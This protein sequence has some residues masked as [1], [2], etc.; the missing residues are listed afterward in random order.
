M[1]RQDLLTE[2][3]SGEHPLHYKTIFLALTQPWFRRTWIIQEI[4]LA[5]RAKFMFQG[6][7]FGRDYLDAT[8]DR[9]ELMRR[10]ERMQELLS[11]ND[12]IQGFMNYNKIKEIKQMYQQQQNDS[13]KM[14]QLTRDFLATEPKDKIYGLMA[15]M[16][17]YDQEALGPY[18]QSLASVFRRFAALHVRYGRAITML[19]SAGI[20]RRRIP[21][22][23]PSW[24]P[25]WTAQSPSPKVIST[26]R[27]IRYAA[28]GPTISEVAL[29][30]DETGVA[31]LSVRGY[32][33]DTLESVHE[34][35]AP[36]PSTSRAFIDGHSRARTA[37]DAWL[38]RG[39]AAN[40]ANAEEAFVRLLL[41]DDMYTGANAIPH[42]SPINDPIA[43]YK[44]ALDRWSKGVKPPVGGRRMDAEET[45]QMQAETACHARSFAITRNG[46]LALVPFISR[47]GDDIVV[48]WGATVP[49]VV[50]RAGMGFRLVGDGYVQGIMEGEGVEG[51]GQDRLTHV[52]LV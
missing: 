14:I 19:D 38:S 8:L 17:E 23:L 36:G 52:L 1:G 15:L 41:M 32:L 31:G 35:M 11:N 45:F 16:P 34:M 26:L 9:Q 6:N 50:R 46:Y 20:Q 5:K 12:T 24:V 49:Y 42:S 29:A 18:S 13:L 10:P 39:G 30:G 28:G 44:A 51:L 25:D 40:Y 4:T 47:P 27:P 48:F 22:Y 2:S 7:V 3:E 37:F 21:E 43:T 33:I